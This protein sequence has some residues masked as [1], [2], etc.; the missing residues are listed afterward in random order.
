M[1]FNLS[2]RVDNAAFSEDM[3]NEIARILR[4]IADKV[5]ASGKSIYWYQ[6]IFDVNGNNIG[7]FAVKDDDGNTIESQYRTAEEG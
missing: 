2:M 1:R 6:D 4:K 3:N 7:Q 5:E